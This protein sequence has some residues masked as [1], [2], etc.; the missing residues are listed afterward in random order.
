MRAPFSPSSGCIVIVPARSSGE[1][2]A[3]M[4]WNTLIAL[5]LILAM[6]VILVVLLRK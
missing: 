6:F 5:A 2:V 4:D 1:C 3:S